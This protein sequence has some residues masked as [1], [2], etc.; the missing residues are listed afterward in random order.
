MKRV[1]SLFMCLVIMTSF[2]SISPITVNAASNIAI[3]GV[4]IGYAAKEYFSENG[5][6]CTCHN[7]GICLVNYSK[8]NCIVVNAA[9]QCKGFALHCQNKLFGYNEKS[10][11]KEF[12]NIGSI[13]AGKV[14]TSNLKELISKSPI[15]SHIRTGSSAHSMVLIAKSDSGFTIVQANGSNNNEYSSW[16]ACRIGTATYT[17]KSYVNS[18]YGKRGIAYIKIPKDYV[19]K[20]YAPTIKTCKATSDSAIK[21]TWSEVSGA[22]K[23]KIVRTENNGENKKEISNIKD[24]TYTDTGLKSGTTYYYTVY[25]INGSKT[26]DASDHYKTYT[27]PKAPDKP[28]VT[29]DSTS[30]LTIS[31][32]SVSG[33]SKYQVIYHKA[34]SSEWK[35]LADNLD[36]TSYVHKNLVAGQKYY[37]RVIAKRIGNIGP[38]GN[39][40]EQVVSSAQSETKTKFTLIKEPSHEPNESN[41]A[42]VDLSWS[43]VKGDSSY[44]YVYKVFRDGKEITSSYLTTTSYTDKTA[45]SDKIHSYQI[46]VYEKGTDYTLRTRCEP[47]YGGAKLSPSITAT[48]ESTKTIKISWQTPKSAPSGVQYEVRRKLPSDTDYTTIKTTT[49]TSYTDTGLTAGTTYQYYVR[50]KDSTGNYITRITGKTVTLDIVPSKVALNKTALTLTEG[51]TANLTATITPSNSFN[52]SITWSTSNA[53]MASVSS[54]GVVTAKRAGTVDITAKTSN[55]I[56]AKCTITVKS[57]ACTYGEWIIDTN[58]ACESDGSKHRVCSDCGELERETILATGHSYSA[59]MQIIKNATCSE[60]GEKAYVCATC[61]HKTD[62]IVIDMTEHTFGDWEQETITNCTSEGVEVRTCAACS[63]TETRT[64]EPKDHTYKLVAE[65]EPTLDAPGKR[66]YTCEVCQESYEEEWVNV[67]SEGIVSVGGAAPDVGETVTIPV[68]IIENPGIAGFTFRVNYDKRVLTPKEITSGDLITSGNFTS[69]LEQGIP[70]SELDKV[71]VHWN[72]E[73]N[74]TGDGTLFNVVF[75]VSSTATEGQYAI[76]LEYENGDITNQNLD[77]VMP[78]VLAN[79]ITIADVIRGDV[80]LDRVVDQRDGVLLSRYIGG[81]KLDFTDKQ[82]QAAN[83]YGDSNINSK[84]GV[85]LSQ[86]LVGYENLVDSTETISL[87]STSSIKVTVGDTEAIA[88]DIIYI[89][90]SITDNTGV[91]GF[92]LKLKYDSKYLTPLS[93]ERGDVLADGDFSTNLDEDTELDGTITASWSNASNMIEDGTLF[94]VEFLISDDVAIDQTLAITLDDDYVL[95]NNAL[96]DISITRE[97]SNIS[98]INLTDDGISAEN[99]IYYIGGATLIQNE[100]TVEQIP[101]NGNFD[102][103]VNIENMQEEFVDGKI[104]IALYDDK[105]RFINMKTIDITEEILSTGYALTYIDETKSNIS[106]IKIFVW[107][108]LSD[109]TPLA[110]CY[111]F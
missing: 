96:T 81:W 108:S 11:S 6:A 32:N 90:V 58:V 82:K 19:D 110:S 78:T 103:Q 68:N 83:V 76:W 9:V 31:W 33:A 25:A 35:T 52:K 16:P 13:D 3:N 94:I 66:T 70:V 63:E 8:C 42:Y 57:A 40:T 69:N 26:S 89:P 107:G 46:K 15:G 98:I 75:D 7:K 79:A 85:R 20:L 65:T 22:D 51:E 93:V 43:A 36:V 62:N 60:Q 71:I 100:S 72:T 21:I 99:S 74:I 38:E 28:E 4:D 88:G 34:G 61:G 44:S 23:Y 5:K 12:K 91:A 56:T 50:V 101:Q 109:L 37:Y 73:S 97:S 24:E 14:T 106:T 17:W 30:Q 29:Q 105:E 102:I 55:G 95:C 104:I 27:K 2:I 1:I 64:T 84:D 49:A 77:D 47:F 80:N 59:E 54:S 92:D 87:M 48:P 45:S 111:E 39:K 67:V 10:K 53:M 86:L 18:T 41:N